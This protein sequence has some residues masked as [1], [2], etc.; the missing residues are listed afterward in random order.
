M[1]RLTSIGPLLIALAALLWAADG[2]LR[3][4]LYGLPPL[5]IV[6][7]EHAVGALLLLPF[8]LKHIETIASMRRREWSMLL[9]ISI[10]SS[11]LGTLWFTTA[12]LKVNFIPFSVVFLLQKLQPVFV[13]TAAAV[14]LKERI[15]KAY[16]RYALLAMIAAYFVT[17]PTGAVNWSTGNQTL[18]AAFFALAAAFA[19][20]TSTIFS[21]IALQS[22]PAIV[23]TSLRF[24]LTAGIAGVVVLFTGNSGPVLSVTLPQ[25]LTLIAIALSTGM[26]ALA[27]YYKGLA[28]TEAKVSTIIELLFPVAAVGIDA[29]IYKTILTPSQYGAALV[30][31]FASY[32][33]A[34][35]RS[36]RV[37]F[38]TRKIKGKG[39]G[40]QMG[41]PTINMQIPKTLKLSHGIYASSISLAGKTYVGALHY[42]PIPTF[43]EKTNSLEVFLLDAKQ[44]KDS[45][46]EQSDI[47]VEIIACI[48][49]IYHFSSVG[50]LVKQIELDVARIRSIV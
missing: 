46:V 10:F 22:K 11:L 41:F 3:R 24:L 35:L 29:V 42:G 25:L 40:K 27:I 7:L 26:V 32:R 23:V 33:L 44:I 38:V 49:P 43:G 16:I 31:L 39:R 14:L 9:L 4:S 1:K 45:V 8:I 12:L 28:V 21:K 48:R 47:Q 20:G 30:L 2:V 36:E 13:I 50:D 6:F 15:T 5:V 18:Q 37:R 17:F 34:R 19:W